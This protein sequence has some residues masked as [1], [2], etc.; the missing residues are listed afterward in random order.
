MNLTEYL[1]HRLRELGVGHTFGIPGDFVLPVYAVQE[2]VGMPTIVCAH[3]PGVG[4]AADGYA[5]FRGLGVALVTY[6]PGALN[7]LNPIA[8]AYAEQ[9]PVLVVSGGPEVAL[10]RP[11]L[12]LHHV[13]KTFESQLQ[14][15][16]EVTVDAAILDD[17]ETA[18][19]TIDRV[20]RQVVKWKRPGYLEIPR[21]LVR[22][23]VAAPVGRLALDPSPD[24]SA[25]LAGALDEATAEIGAMLAAAR[26]PILYVGVGVRRHALTDAV[27][28]LAERLRLPVVTDLLGKAAFP[29]SHPQ[30]AGVYLGALG[31]PAVRELIDGS[32]CVLG[33]GVVLTDLGTGFW[34]QRIDPLARVMVDPDC[35]HVRYHRYDGLPMTHVVAALL[36]RLASNDRAAPRFDRG[37]TIESPIV[38]SAPQAVVPEDVRSAGTT[39]IRVADVIAALRSLDQARYS[40]VADVGDSWFISLELRADVYLAAGYYSSMG[41]GVP[42]ALGAGIAEP[43]RRPLVIVG[44]GAFQ[45]TGTELATHV[46]QGLRPIVLLLNNGGYGMLEAIDRP[47]QYYE[48]RNWDY[49]SIARALGAEAERV[50]SAGDLR[51]ALRRA[52]AAPGAYLIEALTAKDDLSPVMARIRNHI[53]SAWQAPA[54]L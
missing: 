53:T 43:G 35:V 47:R 3:E 22:A 40:F 9:S 27:V 26:R 23:P 14:I 49:P 4:F 18:A 48:R 44:D 39:V 8:C 46:D 28:R 36:D 21:D 5:R 33:I 34:T 25:A 52:E 6:G 16:R 10:R 30:C 50:T 29:E 2:E 15:Y 41:F 37:A 12:H 20:L 1:F 51:A 32:D 11:E 54:A 19:A 7:T 17:P 45:M 24:L 31:D 13:I 38:T 42:A